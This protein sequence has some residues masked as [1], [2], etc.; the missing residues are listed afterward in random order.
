[1]SEVPF[2][3]YSL[4][5]EDAFLGYLRFRNA[6][7]CAGFARARIREDS[8]ILDCGCGP[9]SV[10][11][12]LAAWAPRGE[13]VGIDVNGQQLLGAQASAL[14]LGVGNVS[15]QEASLFDL[16][17]EDDSFDFAFSQTVFCHIP[18]RDQAL[19]E[20]RRVLKPGGYVGLRDII[21]DQVV[22]FPEDERLQKLNWFVRQGILSTGGDPDV[23]RVLG[24]LLQANGFEDIALSLDWEQAP[25]DE[26][27]ADYFRNLAGALESG[28]LGQC[29]L[30]QGWCTPE[31]LNDI[32]A[33]WRN[34]GDDPLG[35]SGLPFVQALGRK[36]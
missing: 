23:G 9:G 18:N 11:I 4:G 6:E 2:S 22:I 5:H 32:V 34:L 31:E 13:T 28:G 17:F 25:H 3:D 33:A 27:R 24:P 29:A 21:N 8:R 26:Y 10:T 30:E 35:C 1:M 14:A 20:I 12:G 36:A 19:Q 7:S 16:P 15:F